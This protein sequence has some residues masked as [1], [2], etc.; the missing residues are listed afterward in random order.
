MTKKTS[1]GMIVAA[2]STALAMVAGTAIA[3][4]KTRLLSA[5]NAIVSPVTLINS[6]TDVLGQPIHYPDGGAAKL[7]SQ[8]VTLRAGE[9]TPWHSHSVPTFGYMIQGEITVHYATG[10]AHSFTKGDSLIEAQNMAHMGVVTSALPAK[11][12]VVYAG[13]DGLAN[14]K[15]E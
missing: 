8:I 2:I 12:L 9:R 6:S 14:T 4:D 1:V 3:I 13:T 15:I 7:E 11:I 5:D 10:E